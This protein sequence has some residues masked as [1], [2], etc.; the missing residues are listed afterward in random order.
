M[1]IIS[2]ILSKLAEWFKPSYKIE[3]KED[4]PEFAA[5]RTVYI[6]G[7]CRS[8]WLLCFECPCGCKTLIH[9]NLLKDAKPCWKFHIQKKRR[10][11]IMPSIWRTKGCKSHFFMRKGKISWC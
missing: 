2:K 8:P 10:I 9:L 11:N 3:Y 5:K 6:I 4:P 7:D 1:K